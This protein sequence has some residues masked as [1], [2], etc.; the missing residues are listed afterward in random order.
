M[1]GQDEILESGGLDIHCGL[2]DSSMRPQSYGI[3][4]IT[5]IE[6]EALHLSMSDRFNY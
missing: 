1:C 2:D 6:Q 3:G 5:N 4:E